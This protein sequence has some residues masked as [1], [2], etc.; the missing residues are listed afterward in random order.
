MD[1][2]AEIESMERGLAEVG[3]TARALCDA[4]GVN[5]STWTRWKSGANAPNFGTWGRVRS[6]YSR[7]IG[8]IPSDAA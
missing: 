8:Q 2:R 4:A 5:Q 1:I 3:S 7:L 6:A